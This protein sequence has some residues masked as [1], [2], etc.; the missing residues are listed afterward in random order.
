MGRI[1]KARVVRAVERGVSYDLHGTMDGNP[2]RISFTI[3]AMNCTQEEFAEY[4]LTV[5]DYNVVQIG[6][7]CQDFADIG[8][9]AFDLRPGSIIEIPQS[10]YEAHKKMQQE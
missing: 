2:D 5:A 1:L 7:G 4:L 9:S 3:K 10:T 6:N 8:G